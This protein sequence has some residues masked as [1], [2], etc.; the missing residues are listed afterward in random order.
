MIAINRLKTRV[1]FIKMINGW[2]AS[3][4]RLLAQQSSK[5]FFKE[6]SFKITF[7]TVDRLTKPNFLG[8]EIPQYRP[9]NDI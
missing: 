6:I 3:H 7:K 4:A 8:K 9:R 5:S 2:I 1:I